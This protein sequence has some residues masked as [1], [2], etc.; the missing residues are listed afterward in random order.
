MTISLDS[1]I[2]QYR[3]EL[4]DFEQKTR[5]LKVIPAEPDSMCAFKKYTSLTYRRPTF[6]E[7]VDLV[8]LFSPRI[9][10]SQHWKASCVSCLPLEINTTAAE[11]RATLEGCSVVELLVY[12]YGDKREYQDTKLEFWA[13]IE[14]EL[15]D[16]NVNFPTVWKWLPFVD[17]E[18]DAM[19]RVIRVHTTERA[20]GEDS[21]RKWWSS[22]Q[23]YR[24]S[25]YWADVFNWET[26]AAGELKRN[27]A[28]VSNP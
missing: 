20:L 3:K 9:V 2:K 10:E 8:A 23:N 12:S 7:A 25:Y 11:E 1:L 14:G 27:E 18:R 24:F 4:D 22:D 13:K 6:A 16:V 17:V 28:T 15:L 5:V 19:Q 26:W 21:R